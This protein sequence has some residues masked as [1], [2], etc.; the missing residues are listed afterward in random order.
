M[1]WEEGD[2]ADQSEKRSAVVPNLCGSCIAPFAH[3][4]CNG[5]STG[6]FH[7]QPFFA[8]RSKAGPG[9]YKIRDRYGGDIYSAGAAGGGCGRC[10]HSISQGAELVSGA[11]CH[12][13]SV[14]APAHSG[15]GAGR[16]PMHFKKP[17]DAR[18]RG[19]SEDAAHGTRL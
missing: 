6:E 5:S 16:A 15:W 1:T 8:Y 12:A 4:G 17:V 7:H 3:R 2:N 18:R 9:P 10:Q 19:W 14:R 13:L 11:S